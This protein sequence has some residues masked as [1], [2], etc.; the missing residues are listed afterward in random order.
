VGRWTLRLLWKEQE[1][2]CPVCHQKITTVLTRH[3]S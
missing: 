1:G 3:Q 2:I